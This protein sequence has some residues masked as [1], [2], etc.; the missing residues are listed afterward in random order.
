VWSE[1]NFNDTCL[2]PSVKHILI[3]DERDKDED[4]TK[5]RKVHFKTF[6][7]ERQ[8]HIKRRGVAWRWEE[9][10]PV[11]LHQL[12]PTTLPDYFQSLPFSGPQIVTCNMRALNLRI[13]KPIFWSDVRWIM[14]HQL[15]QV[16]RNFP[17]KRN[18]SSSPGK[19]FRQSYLI[20]H[21]VGIIWFRWK[22]VLTSGYKWSPRKLYQAPR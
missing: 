9:V 7:N 15:E 18:S 8:T 19:H 4:K 20:A 13:F 22:G 16:S 14:S 11:W 10:W 1:D 3:C 21:Q 17:L 6:L 5:C 2:Q 12:C